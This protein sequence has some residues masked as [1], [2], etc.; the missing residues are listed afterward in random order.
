M[1]NAAILFLHAVTGL[2]PGSGTALG[3]VDLPVQRERHTNWPIIPGS[4][5]KGVLREA[6][7]TKTDKETCFALFGP[8]TGADH[9]GALAF[10]DARILAFPVRSLKGVFAWVTC[11]AVLER[12]ARD[13]RVI[14]MEEKKILSLP[15]ISAS[16]QM[17]CAEKSPILIDAKS[18]LLEE[19][20]FTRSG[21]ADAAAKWLADHAA[22]DDA[23]KKRLLSHLVV[24]CDDDFTHFV[25]HATEV[26]AR[27]GLDSETRTVKKGALFWEEFLPPET[28]M[29]ALVPAD[30]SRRQSNTLSA[31]E[32]LEIFKT[33]LPKTLQIGG[34][35]TVGKGLCLAKLEDCL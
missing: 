11:P 14:G 16:D 10:T 4:S 35:E 23:A 13:M 5:L 12:L 30:K 28:L 32:V 25:T 31:G 3:V 9:A 29:Y 1:S 20:E 19:F 21:S 27:V 17:L 6:F 33:G 34:G 8:E 7:R 24:L 15:S 22:V 26:A 2:H 18:A